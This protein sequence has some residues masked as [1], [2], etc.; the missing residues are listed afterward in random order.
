M[1]MSNHPT[2]NNNQQ[3][4]YGQFGHEDDYARLLGSLGFKY[5]IMVQI[6]LHCGLYSKFTLS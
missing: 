4:E 6:C 2:I 5:L 1:S 3:N